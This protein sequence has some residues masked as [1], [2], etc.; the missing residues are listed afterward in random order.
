MPPL[1]IRSLKKNSNSPEEPSQQQETESNESSSQSVAASE[2][3]P[4]SL[5]SSEAQKPKQQETQPDESKE[6]TTTRFFQAIGVI[7]GEVSFDEEEFAKVTLRDQD[8][9]LLYV[10]RQKYKLRAL[11]KYIK[12]TGQHRQRLVVYPRALHVP[13]PSQPQQIQFQLVRFEPET[14]QGISE[15]LD[16]MEFQIAGLWQFIPVCRVP[17]ISVFKN[18]TPERLEWIKQAEPKR[19]VGF[20]KPA[21]LPVLWKDAPVKP[22]KYNPKAQEQEKPAFVKIKAKFLP[23]K[24]AFGFKSLLEAP[25]TEEVPRF[26]KASKKDKQLA[27]KEETNHPH[28]NLETSEK[29]PLEQTTEKSELS[30]D[31]IIN[32]MANQLENLPEI[33]QQNQGKQAELITNQLIA[34]HLKDED[35]TLPK[36]YLSNWKHGRNL[37]KETSKHYPAYRLWQLIITSPD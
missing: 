31:E 32:R 10:P 5:T 15:E 7:E 33:A 11:Q 26:L 21:H 16:N 12:E 20:M 36:N 19:R 28:P 1:Q 8:Y 23:N 6:E 9:P 2:E 14:N 27:Q 30:V 22:F 25:T 17:C 18:F 34:H 37:P 4:D 29:T 35:Y 13:D 3:Q 24:N